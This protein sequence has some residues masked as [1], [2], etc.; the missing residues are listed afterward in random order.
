MLDAKIM[1]PEHFEA[2]A[3]NPGHA[4]A[5]DM[6]L[7]LLEFCITWLENELEEND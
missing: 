5:V 7:E 6:G 3:E 1:H 2:I 4:F